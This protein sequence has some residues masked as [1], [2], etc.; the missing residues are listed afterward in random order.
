MVCQV[1]QTFVSFALFSLSFFEGGSVIDYFFVVFPYKAY[2][3]SSENEH[4]A[5]A[6]VDIKSKAVAQVSFFELDF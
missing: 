3:F 1:G 6:F 2:S 4:L 5:L